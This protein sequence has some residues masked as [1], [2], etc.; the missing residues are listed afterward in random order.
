MT[1]NYQH[2][3]PSQGKGANAIYML[4][5][6]RP[7]HYAKMMFCFE[8]PR[9]GTWTITRDNGIKLFDSQIVQKVFTH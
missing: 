9:L 1:I 5:E 8:L 2:L 7:A 6:E 4:C 3:I